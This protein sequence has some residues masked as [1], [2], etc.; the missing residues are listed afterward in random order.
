MLDPRLLRNDLQATA[1]HLARRDR[2][3]VVVELLEEI[4]RAADALAAMT[5]AGIPAFEIGEVVPGEERITV[6]VTGS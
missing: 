2:E 1:E 4:A 5:D 6:S 3:V